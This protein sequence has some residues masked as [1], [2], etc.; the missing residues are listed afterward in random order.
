MRAL[1]LTLCL[2]VTG[3]SI[4]P[5]AWAL[6]CYSTEAGGQFG[7]RGPG[8]VSRFYI[9]PSA[10][11]PIDAPDGQVVWRGPSQKVSI[12]CYK[13]A[14][15]YGGLAHLQEQVFFWPGKTGG[16]SVP[17]IDGI[18]IGF[19]YNGQDI[20]GQKMAIPGFIVPRC[21]EGENP[22]SCESRTSTTRIITYQPIIVTGPGNFNGYSSPVNIFQVDG[23]L[24]YNGKYANYF[25]RIENMNI[26][27]SSK[28]LV[29]LE[30]KNNNIDYGR[31][32]VDDIVQTEPPPLTIIVRNLKYGADCPS[33]KLR[34]YF[35]NV[36]DL[37]N[38]SYIPVFDE[39]GTEITSFGI[40]LYTPSGEEVQLNEPVGDGYEVEQVGY[41]R[42]LAKLVP[43]DPDNI[44]KG[45]F[46]GM[47][48]YTVSYL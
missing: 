30:I 27:E 46:E 48:V 32:G 47:V 17:F 28:C 39:S 4:A 1:F 44:K 26:L 7:G 6:A 29:E 13:D 2:L 8:G 38:K 41:D 19:R 3:L 18:R 25:S 42:Y 20:Y 10:S 35:D 15:N 37:N 11:V 21:F 12:T 24:G 33:V 36:R 45:K 14:T 43:F 23:Q 16:E 22:R 40:K 31:I 5:N 34:G 9:D